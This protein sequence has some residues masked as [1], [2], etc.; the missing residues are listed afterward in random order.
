[1]K[2]ITATVLLL[3]LFQLLYAQKTFYVNK[4][5]SYSYATG[6]LPNTYD[7]GPFRYKMEFTSDKKL[8]TYSAGGNYLNTYTSAGEPERGKDADGL[9][10]VMG[11]YEDIRGETFFLVVYDDAEHYGY[12]IINDDATSSIHYFDSEKLP[13]QNSFNKMYE[14]P[15]KPKRMNYNQLNISETKET[16]VISEMDISKNE[17]SGF[18]SKPGEDKKVWLQ[19][20]RKQGVEPK[21]VCVVCPDRKIAFEDAKSQLYWVTFI[22]NNN[23]LIVEIPGKYRMIFYTKY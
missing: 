9:T 4:S 11:D 8:I 13:K 19:L 17:I 15:E 20:K 18:F 16:P 3:S 22:R 21:E 14:G 5:E 23:N 7:A 2:K 10:F 12:K 6:F 1:M